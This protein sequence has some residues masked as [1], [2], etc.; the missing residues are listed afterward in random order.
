MLYRWLNTD[1][2]SETNYIR[3]QHRLST[4]R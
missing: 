1:A 3:Q 2:R 4:I